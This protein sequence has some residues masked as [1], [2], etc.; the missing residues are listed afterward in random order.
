MFLEFLAPGVNKG[1]AMRWLARRL[2]HRSARH[3]AIG[4]QLN[5]LEMIAEAGIGVAMPHGPAAV[6]G[7]GPV[8]PPLD[9]EGAAQVI[10]EL[11][12]GRPA[13]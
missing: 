1:S 13:G 9:E 6:R 11:V 10:E 12:L 5:D 8:A 7:G 2:R 3:L 4:D